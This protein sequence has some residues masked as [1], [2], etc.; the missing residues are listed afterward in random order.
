MRL[1]ASTLPTGNPYRPQRYQQGDQQDPYREESWYY[2]SADTASVRTDAP[3]A[4]HGL[5]DQDA[6]VLDCTDQVLLDGHSPEPPPPRLLE[7]EGHGPGK[8]SLHQVL[9]SFQVSSRRW[10]RGLG[11]DP[12][13]VARIRAVDFYFLNLSQLRRE[14]QDIFRQFVAEPTFVIKGAA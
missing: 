9:P 8:A 5:L 3:V 7:A 12:A 4:L 14:L 10:A 13:L 2:L 1:P 11:A 6:D